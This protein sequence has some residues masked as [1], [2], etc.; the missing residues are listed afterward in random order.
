MFGVH[1]A[2]ISGAERCS[3]LGEMAAPKSPCWTRQGT[4]VD[5]TGPRFPPGREGVAEVIAVIVMRCDEMKL[6][7]RKLKLNVFWQ[8]WSSMELAPEG[9]GRSLAL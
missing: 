1:P 6:G 8:R 9:S 5:F 4:A 2:S 7:N 3:R